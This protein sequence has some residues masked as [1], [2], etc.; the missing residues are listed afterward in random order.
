MTSRSLSDAKDAPLTL[1][2]GGF[3]IALFIYS[4]QFFTLDVNQQV[5][6]SFLHGSNLIFHEAGHVIFMPFGDFMTILW[7]SL[8]QCIIPLVVTL[9]F[10]F[11]EHAFYSAAFWLWWFG[12]NL[13]DVALYA[14]DASARSLPL[15]GGMSE[16]AHDWGNLLTMMNLLAY[17]HTIAIVI[18]FIGMIVMAW[19]FIWATRTLVKE[20]LG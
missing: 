16:E 9:V 15:I 17:D 10:I 5:M 2:K 20:Y 1:V 8:G 3:L 6:Y 18:H 12:Q 14:S 19:A 4:L 13:T 11:Q 7:G